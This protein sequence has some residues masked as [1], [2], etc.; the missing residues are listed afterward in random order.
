[1]GLSYV[2]MNI[3]NPVNRKKSGTERMLVDTG[4]NYSLID[5]KRL[6]KMGVKPLRSMEFKLADGTTIKRDIGEVTFS[7]KGREATAPV[8]FGEKG[9]ANILGVVTL[10]NMGMMVD[11]FKREL[12]PLDTV[13]L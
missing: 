12:K 6:K 11:P 9:D 2:N 7:Y 10:E 8:I 13:N 4:A 1:M 5:K 3:A